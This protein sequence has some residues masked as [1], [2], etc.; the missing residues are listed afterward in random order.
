MRLRDP[1]YTKM[2][3]V[4]LPEPTPVLEAAQLQTDLRRAGIEPYAWIVNGSLAAARPSDPLLR[5]RARAELEQIR[6][7]QEQYAQRVIIVPWQI[8]EPTGLTR[9]RRLAERASNA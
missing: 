7:V 4:T 3:L 2:L 9:L 8:E 5:Q 1:E 6:L